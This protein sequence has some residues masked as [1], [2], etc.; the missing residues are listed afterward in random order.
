MGW[1]SFPPDIELAMN[2]LLVLG[3]V[4]ASLLLVVVQW[5]MGVVEVS[6]MVDHWVKHT[7]CYLETPKIPD[8]LV[9]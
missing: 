1:H 5:Y 9:S 8:P 3:L 2:L 7:W 4:E 6:V